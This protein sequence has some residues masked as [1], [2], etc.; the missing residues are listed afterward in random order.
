VVAPALQADRQAAAAADFELAAS[1]AETAAGLVVAA[2]AAAPPQLPSASVAVALHSGR[3]VW[4]R[5][6][7]EVS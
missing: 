3:Q 6:A 1:A 4:R 7:A 2:A 5:W